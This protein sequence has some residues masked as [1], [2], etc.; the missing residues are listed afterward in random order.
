MKQNLKNPQAAI[1]SAFI[2]SA[3]GLT[4]ALVTS[5]EDKP[6]TL[7][8]RIEDGLDIRPHEKLKDAAEDIEDAVKDATN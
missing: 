8:D 1:L 4:C 5:C 3:T 6:R 2:L 7:G